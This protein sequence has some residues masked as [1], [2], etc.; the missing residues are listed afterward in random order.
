M[1]SAKDFQIR[2]AEAV[3]GDGIAESHIASIRS[4]GAKSYHPEI[5]DDWGAPRNGDRYRRAMERGEIFFVA[6]ARA[7]SLRSR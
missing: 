3:D 2:P 4:L 1:T 5:I 7:P 6:V